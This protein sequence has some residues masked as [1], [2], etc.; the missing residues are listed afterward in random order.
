MDVRAVSEMT[1]TP[2]ERWLEAGGEGKQEVQSDC[3]FPALVPE[4]Q[5]VAFWEGNAVGRRSQ[6]GAGPRHLKLQVRV[7]FVQPGF[8]KSAL[9]P[10][11]W[12]EIPAFISVLSLTCYLRRISQPL[13]FPSRAMELLVLGT[14]HMR[15]WCS[16][17]WTQV[18]VETTEPATFHVTDFSLSPE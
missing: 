8:A 14:P 18:V 3:G 4:W 13:C 9:G 1:Q 2:L 7:F 11:W 17:H 5:R 16:C 10:E 15:E 12:F 6:V